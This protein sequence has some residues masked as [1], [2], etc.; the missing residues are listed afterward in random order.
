MACHAATTRR[1][2]SSFKAYLGGSLNQLHSCGRSAEC[3]LPSEQCKPSQEADYRSLEPAEKNAP[4]LA[5]R[6]G[7]AEWLEFQNNSRDCRS[8][9]AQD[10]R[11]NPGPFRDWNKKK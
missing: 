10:T 1:P 2:Y 3:T 6:F 4:T 11:S 8:E 9:K 5:R 7:P